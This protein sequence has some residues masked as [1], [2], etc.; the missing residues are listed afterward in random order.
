MTGQARHDPANG[1]AQ[2][3]FVANIASLRQLRIFNDTGGVPINFDVRRATRPDIAVVGT[4]S[5]VLSLWETRSS[6]GF[7]TRP[8]FN[9]DLVT[10]R[11]VT[12]GSIAYHRSAGEVVGSPAYATLV[13]FDDL[14]EVQASVAFEAIGATMR[15]VDLAAAQASLTGEEPCGLPVLAPVADMAG[16]GLRALFCTVREI[17][18]QVQEA[19]RPD[20]LVLPLIQ[21]IMGY[22]L[23]SVWPRQGEAAAAI[24]RDVPS[25]KLQAALDYIAAN[26]AAPLRLAD[27]AAAAGISVR[28]LQDKFRRDLGRTPVQFI[29]DQRLRRAHQDLIA[30][31]GDPLPVS[32]IARR[33][34]FAHL[35][36]F[37]QRYRKL[38][39]RTPSA[40]RRESG[41]RH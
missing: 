6:S 34:G 36:D 22:Q 10:I 35:G 2:S 33:W 1:R 13:G 8:K 24:A 7:I 41:Q 20:D 32:A 11:F 3:R 38:Y 18:R 5:D 4:Q 19:A 16:P 27:I 12:S 9:A 29:I 30:P 25:R 14:R 26:L 31:L 17:R 28:S 15:A 39:G 37:G 40:M 21:E 23:L